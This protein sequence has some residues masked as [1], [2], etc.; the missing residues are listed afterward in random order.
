[1]NIFNAAA[2]NLK[3]YSMLALAVVFLMMLTPDAFTERL[4][5]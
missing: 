4:D 3:A 5:L 2:Q 1:M